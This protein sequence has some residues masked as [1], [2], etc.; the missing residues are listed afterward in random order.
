MGGGEW[1]SKMLKLSDVINRGE[2][3]LPAG[4]RPP[5]PAYRHGENAFVR[6]PVEFD[7]ILY[8]AAFYQQFRAI[9]GALISLACVNAANTNGK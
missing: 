7:E 1:K 8:C 9:A 4:S 3:K 6:Q 2:T 5:P